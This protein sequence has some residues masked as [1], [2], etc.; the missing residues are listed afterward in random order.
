MSHDELFSPEGESTRKANSKSSSGGGMRLVLIIMAAL[1]SLTLLCCCGIGIFS[2]QMMPQLED[3]PQQA[4]KVLDDIITI[5]LPAGYAP[6]MAMSMRIPM[7]MRARGVLVE[8]PVNDQGSK[9]FLAIGRIEGKVAQEQEFLDSIEDAMR[10]EVG[11]DRMQTISTETLTLTVDGQEIDFTIIKGTTS[12]HAGGGN[13]V[14]ILDESDE[15]AEPADPEQPADPPEAEPAQ[16]PQPEQ[17]P[18]DPQPPEDVAPEQADPAPAGKKVVY[19][20]RGILP[21]SKGKILLLMIVPGEE[22]DEDQVRSML[23]SIQVR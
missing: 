13:I 8:G 7:L 4:Q 6:K 12:G 15:P 21:S 20:V 3:D 16:D 11:D 14:E 19:Q 23:E 10:K 5:D 18:A 22:W 17:P 2:Y 1:G 9:G